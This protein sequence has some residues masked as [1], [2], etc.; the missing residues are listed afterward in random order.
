[1]QKIFKC[2]LML[3]FMAF[4][5]PAHLC[6][7]HVVKG[8]LKDA[9]N[10]E[11]LVGASVILKGTQQ[12]TTTDINGEFVLQL[13]TEPPYTLEISYIGFVKKDVV[14]TGNDL[15]KNLK[16]EVAPENY[17]LESVE[18]KGSRITEK[19]KEAPLTIESM[20][21]ISIKETP[22]ANFY[23]GLG[24]LKGVDL[25]S[26]SIGFKIINTR[27]FNSTSPVRSLQIIDGVDNQAPG[28]NFS[29]GNFLGASELDVQRVELIVGASTAFYGPNAF[30]GVISMTPKDP[31][32]HKG[33]SALVKTGE[34]G[35]VELAFRMANS[36]KNKQNEDKFAYK[37][38]IYAMRANDWEADNMDAT[39]QSKVGVNN[40][41][42]YD[43]VNRYGDE[44]QTNGINNASSLSGRILTPGLGIWHRT[45]YLEKDLVDYNTRNLKVNGSLHYKFTPDLELNYASSFGTGTT[46]Y[47]GENRFS[48]KGILFFQNKI[49]L[50]KKDKFFL[51]A[52][53]TNEDAG[54]SYDAVFTALLLQD[55]AKDMNT[56]SKDYRNY[57]TIYIVPKVKGLPGFD[58]SFPP[59]VECNDE[60]MQA[61]ADSMM[62]WHEETRAYADGVG[63]PVF[64]KLERYEP[65]TVAFD[66]LFNLITSR[67]SFNE[68]GTRFW[69]R[70]AL[71]HVHGEYKFTP[72]FAD[73]TVGSN[74]R[75]Y[76]PN[77]Q[78]TIFVDTNGRK[79]RNYEYGVY[80]GLIK[81]MMA[82]Q[83]KI[84]L[85][86]RLDKNQN[87]DFL[88]SP[89]ASLVYT[90]NP[91]NVFRLS[92][93]SAIRNPTLQDQYLHYNVGRAILLGNINGFDSLVTVQ[94]LFDFFDTRDKDTLYYFNIAPVRPEK[95]KTVE[96]GYRGTIGNNLYVDASYYYSFYRDF[97][98]FQLG[99]EIEYDPNVNWISDIQVYRVAANSYDA[100]TTQGFSIGFNYY[101][102]KNLALSGNYSWNKLDKKGSEDPIIPAYNTPE[103]KFNVNFAGR[104]MDMVIGALRLKNWG[105][106]INYKWVQGF[107][108]EGS[109]QFT[110]YVP[111]YDVL[112]MQ[113]NK[114]FP[115]INTTIKIGAS[116][117]LNQYHY[118]VYGGPRVGRLAYVSLLYEAGKL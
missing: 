54:K 43:A 69:D 10:G 95:V 12:G 71:Y 41:G 81:K 29:L 49:E 26:A 110:G 90:P 13:N 53:A 60:V 86:A 38:N 98:G 36:V 46:V 92:F 97:L 109:P 104:D 59:C 32:L 23:E 94:S 19:Q 82:D 50:A 55:A 116:N 39:P 1:M 4:A 115:K 67:T 70:S 84:S 74:V 77:S 75:L 40:W 103:H 68:G 58:N 31:F 22:A 63:N 64:K 56:W 113:I 79:I 28:L 62:A 96:I 7:Q 48:L 44:N 27:G 114:T 47:Q 21:I 78:G 11:T 30:N 34:R 14:V 117:L 45:G 33:V 111:T 18:V 87:F 91:E 88:V 112:D 66:S 99:A 118:Q 51:R 17:I 61:Y 100:V 9:S 80:A 65:G 5:I 8:V 2:F 108:F 20:D 16:I 57:Y 52:Y 101:L 25:T 72:E 105:F 6:A 76:V 37:L 3:L 35:L 102:P 73:I 89:A 93:S 24:H 85:T 83:L 107:D 106:N 42:S 15:G